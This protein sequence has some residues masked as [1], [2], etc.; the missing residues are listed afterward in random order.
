MNEDAPEIP[1]VCPACDTRTH[2]P[3]PDVEET[4]ARHNEERHDG[5]AV[6]AVDPEVFDR[7]ADYVASDIGLIDG[8][9]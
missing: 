2:I 5:E 6:A 9:R 1:I 4:V 7:L 3:F 8:D